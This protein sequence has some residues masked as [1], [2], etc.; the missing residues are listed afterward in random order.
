MVLNQTR[1]RKEIRKSGGLVKLL[2]SGMEGREVDLERPW[3]EERGSDEEDDEVTHDKIDADGEGGEEESASEEEESSQDSDSDKFDR[4]GEEEK[5]E[6]SLPTA[7]LQ[8]RKRAASPLSLQRAKKVAFTSQN[9]NKLARPSAKPQQEQQPKSI[10][11]KS[12]TGAKQ[13]QSKLAPP[14]E[15]KKA[16]KKIANVSSS[17]KKAGATADPSTYDFASFF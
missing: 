14:N 2:A 15:H 1:L 3:E 11:K 16:A 12:A 17:L 5:I 6:P 4:E 7:V 8:K 10:L 13:K 9:Q